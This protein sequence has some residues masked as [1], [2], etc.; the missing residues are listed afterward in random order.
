MKSFVF[1]LELTLKAQEEDQDLIDG[2]AKKG[3]HND[4]LHNLKHSL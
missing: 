2:N 3:I 4:N 1:E